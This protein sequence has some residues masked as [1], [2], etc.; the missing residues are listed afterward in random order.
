MKTV[1]TAALPYANGE[2]HLGHVKST[3][4]PA[5]VYTRFLK[6]LGEEAAYVCA[7]DEHGTPILF[8]AEEEGVPPD[9]YIRKWR[10]RHLEDL[11]FLLVNFDAFHATHTPN[12]IEMTQKIYGKLQEAGM[13]FRQTVEQYWSPEEQ[14]PLPDRYVVGTCPFCGTEGQYADQCESC[15]KVIPPGQLVEP[16]SKRRGSPVELREVE[17]TFFRLSAASDDLRD[18]VSTVDTSESV[19]K[20]VLNW[21]DEGL[22]DWDIQR[23]I[24]WGVPIPGQDGVFYV[25][26]DAPIG[27]ISSLHKWCEDQ[28]EDFDSWWGSR[29]V[30]FIGK[31][32][33]YHHFLFWPAML[34]R[35]GYSLPECIPVRG[36]LN[37]EGK[38]F[39]KS[40]GWYVSLRQ[41]REAGFD[42]EYLRFYMTFTTPH[43]MKDSDFSAGEFTKTVNEELANNFGNLLHRVL[44]FSERYGREIPDVPV[45]DLFDE[46]VAARDEFED[47]M[48]GTKLAKALHVPC[49]LSRKLNAYFQEE[50]PWEN[51]D[52]GPRVVRTVASAMALI[53]KFFYPF[54]PRKAREVARLLN[55]DLEW[56][57]TDALEPGHRLCEAKVVFPKV[58]SDR[59]D[60]LRSLYA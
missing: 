56:E 47:L 48:R 20:F 59:E 26:F 12:H 10:K 11:N 40:R 28:D 29:V 52:A 51:E 14:A 55:V 36:F 46:V 9:K 50:A 16:K 38:K 2:L 23:D 24:S 53:N 6:F 33:C 5:D 8:K 44:K 21:I 18:F 31:D 32:I 15:G 43:G 7:T 34:Q 49:S 4:L 22:R 58:D 30:H 57:G 35:A 1:V 54:I 25:W 41:W 42:P 39:S 13:I 3:Y 37:L 60:E 17:H 27:Y 45:D 19:R